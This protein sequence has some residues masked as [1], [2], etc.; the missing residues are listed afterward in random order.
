MTV[1][2]YHIVLPVLLL[3]LVGC[4]AEKQADEIAWVNGT[5][6]E[7][8]SGSMMPFTVQVEQAGAP[9]GIDFRGAL[10][11]G[12]LRVQLIDADGESV[13]Q[14]EVSSAGAF[15]V[16]T[17]V[18]A[19]EAGKY[20]LGLAW[21]GPVQAQYSLQY[22]HG[23]IE[24]PMISPLAL[25]SGLGMIAVAA[26]YI[27]Y[28]IVTRLSGGYLGLGALAWVVAVALK[29]AWAIPVNKL[30]YNALYSALPKALAGPVFYVYV[31][32]LTGVFEV[33]LVWLVLRYT[34]LGKA[35]WRRVLAF[36]IGFGV[37]EALLLGLSSLGNVV[38]A[39]IMPNMFPPAALEQIAQASNILYGLA[40]V[41]ERF[42]TVLIHILSNALIFYAVARRQPRWFWLAFVY[43]TLI[44]SVAAYAQVTGLTL[45]KIWVIEAIVAVWG[46]I[47][48]PGTR[49]IARSYPEIAGGHLAGTEG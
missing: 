8:A 12:T 25:L 21:D 36:G 44:D 31:G 42:F 2:L 16:N 30:V 13:W 3:L 48:W 5:L 23:K 47:G 15:V 18:N 24:P 29:F 11:S 34:R 4:Q 38:A 45:G 6:D 41:L 28:V 49:L 1:K 9:V 10:V 22:K 26:G 40:P 35:E 39:M 43:K 7:S 14:E 20:Q 27:V 17:V 33:A 37:V 19:P 46:A 32:L